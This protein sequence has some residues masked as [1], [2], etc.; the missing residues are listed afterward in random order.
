MPKHD[1]KRVNPKVT[2]NDYC[3][4]CGLVRFTEYTA[5]GPVNSYGRDRVRKEP[6]CKPV[7]RVLKLA[8]VLLLFLAS[9]DCNY[10]YAK[11]QKKC[12]GRVIGDTIIVRDTVRVASVKHDTAFYYRQSDTV[13]VREGRLVMKYYYRNDTVKLQGECRDTTIVIE[14]RVACTHTVPEFD[15]RVF[16]YRNRWWLAFIAVTFA[17]CVWLLIKIFKEIKS[18]GK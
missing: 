11:A 16:L 4:A 13:I 3:T 6:R 8:S 5:A 12:A 14:N 1:W 10:H 7:Q 17:L 18:I 15:W 2:G 9:C